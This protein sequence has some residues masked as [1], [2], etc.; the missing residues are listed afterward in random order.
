MNK[1][2]QK[3]ILREKSSV[4]II[5]GGFTLIELLVV[6]LIIGI[7][8][9]LALPQYERAVEKSRAAQILPLLRAVA[10]AQQSYY[11]AN[12]TYS[13]S[14]DNLDIQ[15]PWT[16]KETP[17]S[18]ADADVRSNADWSLSINSTV[19][20]PMW[21]WARRM[22]GNYEGSGIFIPLDTNWDGQ[23][24]GRIYCSDSR[25]YQNGYCRE[26][27]GVTAGQGNMGCVMYHKEALF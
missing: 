25:P 10:Q 13:Y 8:A 1:I 26:V 19:A 3:M 4:Q 12:G 11:L 21:I 22:N 23:E 6:V 9:A 20:N 27:F 18:C 7:L 5:L 24:P 16:E 2:Y 14:F 15:I 17:F